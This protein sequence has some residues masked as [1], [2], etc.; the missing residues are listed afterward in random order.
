MKALETFVFDIALCLKELGEF[1]ALLNAKKELSE[2]DDV[3]PFFRSHRHLLAYAGSL[4]PGI[5][6]FNRVSL[7]YSIYGDFRADAIIGDWD[8]KSYC[9]IEFEDARE[10]SVFKKSARTNL[11]WSSRFEHGYSQIIDWLWKVDDFRQSGTGRAIFGPDPFDFMGMLVIGRDCFL[12]DTER[13]RLNWRTY[14]TVINSQRIFCL[15]F[16]QLARELRSSLAA[17]G[18]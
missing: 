16:D 10:Q 4:A 3:L 15:T 17:Y 7:E 12:G 5:A 2:S 11:E 14:K 9:L 1:E 8:K 13:C 6:S 18:Y